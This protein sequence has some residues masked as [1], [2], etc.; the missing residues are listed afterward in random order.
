M[1]LLIVVPRFSNK[2]GYYFFPFGL[3]YLSSYLKLKGFHVFCLNLCHYEEKY[4][5]ITLLK[6]A[7]S[8]NKI[9]AVLTG[10]MSGNWDIIEDVISTT[11]KINSK[12][13]TILGGAIVTSDPV[14]AMENMKIDYG[15]F[16]E[17]EI[18][19]AELMSALSNNKEVKN[20]DGIIY[21]KNGQLVRN[22]ERAPILNLDLLPFPDYESFGYGEWLKMVQYS[23]VNPFLENF[24]DIRCATIIGSRSCP[25]SCTFCYHP[26]GKIYRQRSL[27]NIFLE[28]DYLVKK[29]KVNFISFSDEL[30]SANTERIN[31]FADRI[32]KYNLYWDAVF[33]VNNITREL[34]KKLKE[35]N[36]V[37]MGY[38]V[39]SLSDKIL[40]SMK[41][42]ITRNDIE[43][44]FKITSEA[45]I[46]AVGIII[47]GDPEETVETINESINWWKAHPQ[48]SI[49]VKFIKA[50]PD[51][52]DYQYALKNSIITD[53]LKHI[54]HN[55]PIVNLTKIPDK[56]FFKLV[57]KITKCARSSRYTVAGTL[58]NSQK[59]N[60]KY[61]NCNFYYLDLECP[62]CHKIEKYKKIVRAINI[63]STFTCK[64]CRLIFKIKQ[65]KAFY[66]DYSYIKIFLN[67]YSM[68]IYNFMIRNKILNINNK[69]TVILKNT[70]KT[71]V[72]SN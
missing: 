4:P 1:N 23:E 60:E 12:I 43:N 49:G 53:K 56:K 37:C 26:L 42:M 35:S 57:K 20:I 25:Y 34:V 30:F 65:K 33:R 29:Y 61:Q 44:A 21:R 32:K 46:L 27:D 70:F 54:R 17:G 13:F 41:K 69:L 9:E 58:I 2:G 28:I 59:L 15:V 63:Y 39:E 64:N 67:K 72:K 22:K 10:G 7:I 16:G 50:I 47:L 52:A 45:G 68:K 6:D 40:K 3:A 55:F 18:T 5:T 8:E 11:K 14:L 71:I 48:Y 38:G 36:L 66:D 19:I 31:Q 62:F 51:S 24:D